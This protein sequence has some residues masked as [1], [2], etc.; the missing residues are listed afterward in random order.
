MKQYSILTLTLFT[1]V[2]LDC[3]DQPMRKVKVGKNVL[4]LIKDDKK[5]LHY[6]ESRLSP[7]ELK[8]QREEK[9]LAKKECRLSIC[10]I[11]SDEQQNE[12]GKNPFDHQS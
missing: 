3:A 7:T 10:S 12:P 11:N 6:D 2:T 8:N 4:A 9:R 5:G 1:T